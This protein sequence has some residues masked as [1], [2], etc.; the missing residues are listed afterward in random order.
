M[1]ICVLLVEFLLQ[2]SHFLA[3]DG[4]YTGLHISLYFAFERFTCPSSSVNLIFFLELLFST[5]TTMNG[6]REI[7][8]LFRLDFFL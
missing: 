5:G 7:E 2:L 6:G 3:T 4:R 8:F 1:S